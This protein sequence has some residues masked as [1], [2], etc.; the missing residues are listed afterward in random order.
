MSI[1]VYRNTV[2]VPILSVILQAPALAAVTESSA[3][4]AVQARGFLHAPAFP[5]QDRQD[6]SVSGESQVSGD[7]N[8]WNYRWR[9]FLRLDSADEQ[10]SHFDIR[11]ASVSRPLG[12]GQFRAGIGKVFWG[13]SES[14]HLVDIVNQTDLIEDPDGEDKLGQPMLSYALGGDAGSLEFFVLPG[15]RPRTFPGEDGRLRFSLPV[16]FTRYEDPAEQWHVDGALRYAGSFG[17][18]ELGLSWFSGTTRDPAYELAASGTAL[19]AVY[20]QIDQAGMDTQF[21]VGGLALKLEAIYRSGQKNRAFIEED[22]GAATAG[23]EYSFARLPGAPDSSMSLSAFLEYL[24]DSRGDQALTSFENDVF[25]GL[26]LDGNDAAG[27][28]IEA[29]IIQDASE[30]SR[31]ISFEA[32]R[33][34][35]AHLRTRLTARFFDLAPTD[36]LADFDDDDYVELEFGYFF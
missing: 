1:Y 10:R 20:E 30:S 33:R 3:N 24:Y 9:P 14:Q 25:A 35:G 27:T 7:A 18:L 11:E 19:T 26:R 4:Y 12:P 6:L 32:E 34:F 31:V 13:V 21:L 5:E 16:E 36:F 29:G 22:F 2:I 28:S 15:F 8:V 17:P 23:F